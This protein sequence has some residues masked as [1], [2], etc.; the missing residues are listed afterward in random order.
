MAFQTAL[1]ISSGQVRQIP[2]ADEPVGVNAIRSISAGTTNLTGSV[3]VSFANSN[4]DLVWH[5]RLD[6]HGEDAVDQLL[7]ERQERSQR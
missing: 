5:E 1:M 4:G 7:G 2:S 3:G 6:D